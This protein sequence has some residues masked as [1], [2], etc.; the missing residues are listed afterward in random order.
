MMTQSDSVS[1]ASF[2][3]IKIGVESWSAAKRIVRMCWEHIGNPASSSITQSNSPSGG[4]KSI[5]H[6]KQEYND[7]LVALADKT[8]PCCMYDCVFDFNLIALGLLSHVEN[9]LQMYQRNKLTKKAPFK[10]FKWMTVHTL[11]CD[12]LVLQ[13]TCLGHQVFL[14][15]TLLFNIQKL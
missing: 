8:C 15:L 12:C 6:F 10:Q 9:T 5:A 2:E 13:S 4:E 14:N 11:I 3:S 1:S 7:I